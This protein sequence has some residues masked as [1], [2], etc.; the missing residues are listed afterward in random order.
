MIVESLS[1]HPSGLGQF[2]IG[3]SVIQDCQAPTLTHRETVLDPLSRD[4][5]CRPLAKVVLSTSET[6]T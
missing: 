5:V 3:V 2:I 4:K 1:F 6:T